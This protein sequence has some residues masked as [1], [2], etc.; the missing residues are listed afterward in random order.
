MLKFRNAEEA[1]NALAFDGIIFQ[2]GALKIRRPKDYLGPES[3][4]APH[5]PGVISTNVPDTP[6]K[7]FIGGLPSYLTD[8]QVIELLKSFG[9]LRAFNLVKEGGTGQ[10]KVG[11]Q[12]HQSSSEQS[13]SFVC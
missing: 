6:N 9:E 12:R 5:V 8:D 11:I 10:S 4:Q 3:E 1:T 13:T 7:I 2:N